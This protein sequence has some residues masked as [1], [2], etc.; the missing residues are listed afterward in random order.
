MTWTG[1]GDQTLLESRLFPKALAIL[2]TPKRSEF[3]TET[4]TAPS[5]PR[6][7]HSLNVLLGTGGGAYQPEQAIVS[8]DMPNPFQLDVIRLNRDSKPDLK[9]VAFSQD[10]ADRQSFLLRNTTPGSFP[11]CNPPDHALG[12]NLCSP[13]RIVSPSDTVRF[14]IAA[15]NQTPGRKVEVWVDGKKMAENLKGFSH[16]SFLDATLKLAPGTHRV[17]IFTAGWDNLVQQYMWTGGPGFTFP[18][19]VK[20]TTCPVDVGIIVCSPLND[21]TLKSPVRA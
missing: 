5:H 3:S 16:Y 12:F 21:T 19:T 1:T 18:L 11:K 17:G 7:S 6:P 4:E 2:S 8:T 15:G 14:S 20:S 13:T 9:F 10:G